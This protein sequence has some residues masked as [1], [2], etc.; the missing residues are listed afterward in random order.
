MK[1]I[2][3]IAICLVASFAVAFAAAADGKATFDAKCQTCHGPNGEG[4]A[5]IAKMM[6]VTM[7]HLGS[8]EVQAHSVDEIKKI[9]T[10]GNGKMKPISGLTPA[11]VDDVAAYVKT[12]KQ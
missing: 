7:K 4:K 2:L 8:K 12:L 1:K 9:V 3:I 11:Q 6:G 10:G 5:A